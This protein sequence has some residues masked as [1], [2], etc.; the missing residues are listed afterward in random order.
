MKANIKLAF[1]VAVTFS[2]GFLVLLGYFFDL[3]FLNEVRQLL[4]RWAVILLAVS[5]IVG[6]INLSR[7][8][9]HRI[10]H[11][12]PG[13]FYSLVLI[14]SLLITLVIACYYGPNAKPSMFIFNY[15]QIPIEMSLFAMLAVLLVL[16]SVRLLHEQQSS[17]SFLFILVVITVLLGTI[18]IPGVDTLFFSDARNWLTQ[19]W[20][21]AGARG[22]LLGI[23]LGVIATGIR[24]LIGAERPYTE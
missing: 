13:W 15:I 24:V 20:A 17:Y 5:V 18:S 16:F 22:I 10:R 14:L 3:G 23:A 11:R 9:F 7:V 4:I 6:G 21:G 12:Q 1:L 8:H 2:S 19:V